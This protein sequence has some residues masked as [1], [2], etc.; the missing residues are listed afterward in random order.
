MNIAW[1]HWTLRHI[2][3]L[4]ERLGNLEASVGGL[5]ESNTAQ[6]E[7]LGRMRAFEA[8]TDLINVPSLLDTPLADPADLPALVLQRLAPYF[9]GGLLV[10]R[11]A[12]GGPWRLHGFVTKGEFFPLNENERIDAGHLV[13]SLG[14]DQVLKANAEALL[15]E[16][17]VPFAPVRWEA[18]AFLAMP[19]PDVAFILISDI[20]ALWRE[21]HVRSSLRLINDAFNP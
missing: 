9:E 4:V 17:P 3:G 12:G 10:Q 2:R 19:A 15:A 11:P 8:R 20:P 1:P 14:P 16:I 18:Q 21:D 7:Q 13:Q 6:A 5:L